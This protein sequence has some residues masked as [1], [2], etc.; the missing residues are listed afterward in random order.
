M[1]SALSRYSSRYSRSSGGSASNSGAEKNSP[2]VRPSPS[3]MSLIVSN[4]GFL[5]FPYRMF[6]RLDGGSAQ[7][8]ARR[9]T[10]IFLS[11]HRRRMRIFTASVALIFFSPSGFLSCGCESFRFNYIPVLHRREARFPGAACRPKILKSAVVCG[12]SF[13]SISSV[14]FPCAFE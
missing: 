2:S 11:S 7:S 9:L 4:L 1:P 6:L 12:L 5:L 14:L 8:V 10:L 3:Q 13:S